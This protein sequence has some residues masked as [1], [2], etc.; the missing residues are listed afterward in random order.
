[1]VAGF[2]V[3]RAWLDPMR[4]RWYFM[5]DPAKDLHIIAEKSIDPTYSDRRV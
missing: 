2:G 3:R 5:G 1:M 4:T